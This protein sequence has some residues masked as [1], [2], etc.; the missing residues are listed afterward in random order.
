M[1]GLLS[2]LQWAFPTGFSLVN[3]V[4]MVAIWRK[5]RAVLVKDTRDTWQSIAESNNNALI[6]QNDEIR[7]LR[8]AVSRLEVIVQKLLGCKHYDNCPARVL[9]QSYKNDYFRSPCNRQPNVQQ[10]TH[11]YARN[12]AR[13]PCADDDADIDPP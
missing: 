8:E 13:E 1:D 5:N 7:N 10:K 9:V 12:N 4:L 11:R 2:V 3:L 6:K